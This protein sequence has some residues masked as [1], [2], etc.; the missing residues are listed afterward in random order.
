MFQSDIHRLI[1]QLFFENVTP[2]L[3]LCRKCVRC[4]RIGEWEISRSIFPNT[5]IFICIGVATSLIHSHNMKNPLI[6]VYLNAAKHGHVIWHR[7]YNMYILYV[8]GPSVRECI[9]RKIFY[10]RKNSNVRNRNN[11][12]KKKKQQISQNLFLVP[13]IHPFIQ[14]SFLPRSSVLFCSLS[15][16]FVVSEKICYDVV[17]YFNRI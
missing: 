13:F 17:C 5:L 14:F 11:N 15:E 3:K 16:L 7:I 12:T 1:H 8:R 6:N 2:S 4:F 9:R 10:E